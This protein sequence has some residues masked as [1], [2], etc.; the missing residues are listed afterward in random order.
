[1]R[2]HAPLA[3]LAHRQ[4]GASAVEFAILAP[5][6]L[7]LLV[8]FM[9]YGIYFSA[10]HSIQQL[11]ADAARTSVAG[12]DEPERN[13]LV[14]RFIARNAADYILVD[15]AR[16]DVSM[17]D[18]ADDPSQYRVV[19]RYDASALPIWNLYVPLPLPGRSIVFAS[20]IRK[21][22]L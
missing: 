10:A 3:R 2:C 20:S 7:L 12:L 6:F 22:G 18:K 4:D 11:A 21:G 13:A 9:A 15:P 16:L 8:G 19:V 5:V 1:M 14:A 17:G